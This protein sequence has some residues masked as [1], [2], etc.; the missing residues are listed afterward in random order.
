M[1]PRVGALGAA[2]VDVA[3]DLALD[4]QQSLA[5]LRVPTYS[6][7]CDPLPRVR[8]YCREV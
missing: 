5:D 8:R 1:Q 7:T 2:G 4:L 6:A 3:F